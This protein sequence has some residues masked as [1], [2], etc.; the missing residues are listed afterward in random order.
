MFRKFLVWGVRLSVARPGTPW[1]FSSGALVAMSMLKSI[2]TKAEVIDL[3]KTKPGDKIII[4]HLDVTHAQQLK[5]E[6]A[7]KKADKRAT[8]EA[9]RLARKG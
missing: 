7:A 2:T 9:K 1:L 4:E 3:S 8:K 6:K 5:Q